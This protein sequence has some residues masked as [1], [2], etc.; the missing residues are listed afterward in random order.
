MTANSFRQ[1]THGRRQHGVSVVVPTYNERDNI[2]HLLGRCLKTAS[3]SQLAL[4]ILVVD[5]DSEDYT[6]LYPTRLFG[7]DR[8]V[9]VIRRQTADRGLAQSVVDGFDNAHH[10]YIAVI[11][12]DCQHPPEKLTELVDALEAGADISI[13]S[14]HVRGG[15][16]ENWPLWRKLVSKGATMC[17]AV[18]LPETR[19]IS[20]PLSG[21]FAVR[22]DVIRDLEL[23]PQGYKI[24]L[25]V[26]AKG[27]Y[28][29]D[30]VAEVPYVFSERERGDSKLTAREYQNFLEHLG[31]LSLVSRGVSDRID[32]KRAV[33]CAEFGLVGATGS[34]V[35]MLVFAVCT[36]V[37]S[38]HFLVAGTVAFMTAVHW[39]FALNYILTYDRPAGSTVRQYLGFHSVSLAGFLVY[40]ATLAAFV[41]VNTPALLAN[42]FAILAG[43]GINFLGSDTRVFRSPSDTEQRPNNSHTAEVV[44]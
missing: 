23:D 3:D 39:N 5:D 21:F 32:P 35:N 17:T 41:V 9:R 42:L 36:A 25:E 11:D 2:S 34:L 40:T 43:A 8:R 22:Q 33:R 29:A 12:G 24:L 37:L 19:G 1:R 30:R 27:N 31:Q 20:D 28:D 10:D 18:A 16:I 26:L 7:N 44:E 14:R 38:A 13:G 4:E 6:W 15:H